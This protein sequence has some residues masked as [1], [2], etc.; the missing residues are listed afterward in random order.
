M[1]APKMEAR[2]SPVKISKTSPTATLK[3]EVVRLTVWLLLSVVSRVRVLLVL[4]VINMTR[5]ISLP[6]RNF[7]K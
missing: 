2:V 6:L 7:T 4:L 5:P 3:P 1:L